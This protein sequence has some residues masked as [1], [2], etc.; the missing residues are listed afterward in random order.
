MKWI[1]I[2][3]LSFLFVSCSGD[4]NPP[5]NGSP[6]FYWSGAKVITWVPPYFVSE[7]KTMLQKDFGG[8]GM[9]DGITHLALQF[10]VPNGPQ[11]SKATRYGELSDSDIEWFRDWGHEN[12]IKVLLCVYNG[13]NGWDW[14]LAK[15]SFVDNR[16]AFVNSLVS[17]ME[18]LELDGIEVDLEGLGESDTDKDSFMEFM[19]E[20]SQELG[21]REKELTIATFAYIWN[22]PNSNWWN[23]LNLVVYGITSMGYEEIGRNAEGWRSYASQK[24]FTNDPSKLML[25]MPGHLS[26][27]QGNTV[28]E[29]LDWIVQDGSVG[30]GIWD[31]TLSATAWQTAAVWNKLKEIRGSLK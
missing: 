25:G 11:V 30:V 24:S 18:R 17:E 29:Q 20:L 15:E 19:N 10:W 26:E 16:A 14:A 9:K 12:Q 28:S 7:S 31:A 21:E 23:D 8:V 2:F 13:E 5:N 22:K 3:L 1:I 4:D 27:W 6:N